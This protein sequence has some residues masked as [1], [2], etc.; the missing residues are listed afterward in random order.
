M[1]PRLEDLRVHAER[2]HREAAR[3]RAAAHA[4][5]SAICD[6]AEAQGRAALTLEEDSRVASLLSQRDQARDAEDAAGDRLQ[7]IRALQAE[8][9]EYTRRGAGHHTAGGLPAGATVRA[10]PVSGGSVTRDGSAIGTWVRAD[11]S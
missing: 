1:A 8:E 7:R 11:G 3:L 6:A 10:R 2:D 9:D 4:E 5:A